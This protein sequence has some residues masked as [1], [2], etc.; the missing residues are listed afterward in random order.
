[1]ILA[2]FGS[3]K[4]RL[5]SPP[6]RPADGDGYHCEENGAVVKQVYLQMAEPRWV[7]AVGACACKCG[8][9]DTL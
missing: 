8:I 1:M 6:V 9:F 3:E 7:M 4:S 5:F 2:R